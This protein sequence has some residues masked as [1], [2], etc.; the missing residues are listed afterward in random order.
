VIIVT[1]NS[2]EEIGPC[3]DS[4][5]GHTAPFPATVTV[6]DNRSTDGTASFVRQRY[7][8]VS[9]ID[10]GSNTGFAR[11][12]NIGIRA[13]ASEYVLLLNP[14]TVAPAAAIPTLIR[15]LASD[16]DVAIAGP[17]LLNDRN[18]PEL[19]YGPAVSPWTE[20]GQMI[21]RRL[22]DRKLRMVVRHIDRATRVGGERS[23]VSG[24]CLAARRSDLEAVGLFDERYTMYLEDVDLCTM[25]RKRGRKVIFAPQAEV[26]H[27]RGRSAARN[28]DTPRLRRRSHVAYY[29][30]HLPRWSSLLRTYLRVT[31]K[32]TGD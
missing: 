16:P 29:D 32:G 17:R 19:S 3:L 13:T 30:K 12:N 15:A 21:V 14:D 28:T 4:V 11:A 5:V 7:P 27:L 25:V 6:V 20:L 8:S 10:A 26:L 2:R 31:G 9:V 24:A 23:W 1:Y 18:F 22:Y